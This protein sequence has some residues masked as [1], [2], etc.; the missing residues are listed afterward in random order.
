[1]FEEP[2]GVNALFVVMDRHDQPV[3]VAA[4]IENRDISSALN[5]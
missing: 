4:D 1:V 5:L 3:V 2:Q